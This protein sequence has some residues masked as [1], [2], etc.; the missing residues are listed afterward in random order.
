MKVTFIE[1]SGFTRGVLDYFGDDS[2][3]RAFQE[4][5]LTQPTRGAVIQ[6]CGGLR[7]VRWRDVRRAKGTRGGLRIIYL[8]MPEVDQILLLDV[9]DKDETNDLTAAERRALAALADEFRREALSAARQPV[10]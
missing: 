4:D 8:H 9:Y 1:A 10:P 7:K 2:N 5:L 3:Y 6:G